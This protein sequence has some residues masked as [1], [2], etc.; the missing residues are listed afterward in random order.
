MAAKGKSGGWGG[1]GLGVWEERM[2][3]IIY[4]MDKQGPTVEHRELYSVSCNKP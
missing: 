3:T 1:G 4:M 2:Q